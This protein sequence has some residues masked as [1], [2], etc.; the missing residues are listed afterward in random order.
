MLAFAALTLAAPAAAETCGEKVINDWAEDF[1]VDGTYAL[2]CYDDAIEALPR[3]VR[4]YSSAKED[5]ERAMQKVMR[6]NVEP[7]PPGGPDDPTS[8]G[9]DDPTDTTGGGS[10][11]TD[12]GDQGNG[13]GDPEATPRPTPR[14]RPTRSRCLCS[15]SPAS[16]SS[17]SRPA[18]WATSSGAS[19]RGASRRL[20]TP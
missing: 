12:G 11:P 17:C 10:G 7:P 15:C 8:T 20:P 5:I 14:R 2:H 19:R 4:D 18:R 6:E 1:R 3:D 16:P 9:V 13:G